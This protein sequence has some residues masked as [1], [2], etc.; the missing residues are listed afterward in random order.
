[1]GH[2]YVYNKSNIS[3]LSLYLRLCYH[4]DVPL[5]HHLG[6]GTYMKDN[7]IQAIQLEINA[8]ELNFSYIFG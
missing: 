4:L 5:K 7:Q 6:V 8:C 2:L 1:M 3:Y